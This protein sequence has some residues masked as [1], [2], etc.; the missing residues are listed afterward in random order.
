MTRILNTTDTGTDHNKIALQLHR[1][2]LSIQAMDAVPLTKRKKALGGVLYCHPG[3][4]SVVGVT[5]A[6][7]QAFA[8]SDFKTISGIGVVRAHF[9]KRADVY[10][11]LLE[12][13]FGFEEFIDTFLASDTCVLAT[14]QEN[15]TDDGLPKVF[16]K[17]DPKAGMFGSGGYSAK[18]REHIEGAL[19]RE[20]HGACAN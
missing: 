10:A 20:I 15:A 3:A 6:A 17:I 13:P 16:H 4:W 19:L 12:R 18:F 5:D 8:D 1:S 11:I 7:L 2:Y 9:Q 14:T